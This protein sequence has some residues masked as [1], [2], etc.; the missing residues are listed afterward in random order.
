MTNAYPQTEPFDR[1]KAQLRAL[2]GFWARFTGGSVAVM[3]VFG[4]FAP[5]AIVV[6][7][8][9]IGMPILALVL[10][11]RSLDQ[12]LGWSDLDEGPW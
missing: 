8:L 1:Y 6:F 9:S 7:L 4:A 5:L 10:W 2:L 11:G 12:E 3:L